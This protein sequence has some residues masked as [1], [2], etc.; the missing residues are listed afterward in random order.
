MMALVRLF[1][2]STKPLLKRVGRKSKKARI[3][4]RQ[5][6]KADKAVRISLGPCPLTLAIQR[7]KSRAAVEAEVVAYQVRKAS[8]SCHAMAISGKAR[9]KAAREC[10]SSV[11]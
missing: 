4:C 3:S 2:P 7:S 9:A 5:L 6:R 11:D 10:S 1:L 8:L